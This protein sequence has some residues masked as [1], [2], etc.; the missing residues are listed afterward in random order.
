VFVG[1]HHDNPSEHHAEARLLRELKPQA[2]GLEMVQQ[3]FQ[4]VLDDYT[5]GSL[6]D[7]EL[8]QHTEWDTRWGWSFEQY[9][10]IFHHCRDNNVQMLA[11]N[12]DSEDIA[13]VQ[14]KG[15]A[16]LSPETQRRYIPDMTKF[17]AFTSTDAFRAHIKE[18]LLPSYEAHVAMGLY[19]GSRKSLESYLAVQMLWDSAMSSR[20]A[21]WA[22]RNPKALFVGFM[23]AK[24][25]MYGCGA[26]NRF[27]HWMDEGPNAVRT[28][29]MNPSKRDRPF[30]V[31]RD[32]RNDVAEAAEVAARQTQ[33][34]NIMKL[35]DF[36]MFPSNSVLYG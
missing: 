9:L 27:A 3:R 2:V 8:R 23:G 31:F 24:H 6:S 13:T 26:P 12:V 29:V 15:I 30:R 10:P 18:V 4:Q 7:L 25:M 34:G 36:L 33:G 32:D 17:T 35:A 16:G 5:R 20:A 14:Q 28:V 1:E 21:D 19:D 22:H 11:L